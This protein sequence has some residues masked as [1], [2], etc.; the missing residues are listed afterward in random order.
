MKFTCLH[1]LLAASCLL[2]TFVFPVLP[3]LAQ[4]AAQTEERTFAEFGNDTV[5]F[6]DDARVKTLKFNLPAH[7]RL[8]GDVTLQL[9]MTVL[10][11]APA[12]FHGTVAALKLNVNGQTVSEYPIKTGGD[13]APLLII[14][15]GKI[16]AGKMDLQLEIERYYPD[17]PGQQTLEVHL[18]PSS[19]FQFSYEII[20]PD[21]NLILFPRQI[22][23]ESIEPDSALLVIPAQPTIEELRSGLIVAAGLS[24]LSK[25]QLH[26]D[27]VSVGEV[28]PEMQAGSHLILVGK[29]EPFLA[30]QGMIFP[31]PIVVRSD[32]EWTVQFLLP[33]RYEF[34][35]TAPD[36]GLIQ[37][38]NSP[39]NPSRFILLVS[40]ETD[41]GVLKAAQA[42]SSG[43]LRK[44]VFPN[45]AIVKETRIAI[46]VSQ[47]EQQPE[48]VAA[49]VTLSDSF[50]P[51]T[52]DPTLGTTAFI[53]PRDDISA[54]RA[55]M[56]IA[57][58]LGAALDG[59]VV[60]LSAYFGDELA[61]DVLS[62]YNVLAI[63]R[64]SAFPF[65]AEFGK[66][67]PVS[68]EKG[69]DIPEDAGL[70]ITYRISKD[71]D[72]AGYLEIFSS[73]QNGERAI[74]AVLGNDAQGLGWAVTALTSQALREQL[75]GNFALI[76][77]AQV[78][79]RDTRPDTIQPPAPPPVDTPEGTMSVPAPPA[80]DYLYFWQA[81]AL[82]LVLVVIVQFVLLQRRTK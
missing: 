81:G 52:S 36:D 51:F 16:P 62:L 21:T 70:E 49:S 3:A 80:E 47:P 7:W 39:W 24:R 45:L 54:W 43:Q 19:S 75:T 68:F 38:I 5:T 17:Q 76:N 14:P 59:D 22:L 56:Q 13:L 26:L 74:L 55:S 72:S 29:P 37:L 64:A 48:S 34:E 35:R 9:Q 10:S 66:A 46:P 50:A 69:K 27:L 18:H 73:P 28:T 33:D 71:Y 30:L 20:T 44:N 1:K 63:G 32:P 23:Q 58:Q 40:G 65:L 77:E 25:G 53:L 8:T 6:R 61:V 15:Y 79:T 67:L 42:V 57:G 78:F 11:P 2:A 4:E 60:D 82:L 31:S 12:D 41:A